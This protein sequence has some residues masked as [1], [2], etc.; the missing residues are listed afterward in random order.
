MY[1]LKN[2]IRIPLKS[3]R[4]EHLPEIYKILKQ[5]YFKSVRRYDIIHSYIKYENVC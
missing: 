4:D 2:D 3:Q 5:T 1:S